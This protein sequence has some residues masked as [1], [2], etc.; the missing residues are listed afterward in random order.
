[1][2]TSK[3]KKICLLAFFL[4]ICFGRADAQEYAVKSNLLYDVTA[5]LNAGVE[6]RFAPQWT[7][8]L[9]GNL[10]AWTFRDNVKWKH[11]ML[12][13]EAR[14]WFCDAWAGHFVGIHAQGGQ[15][16][17]GGIDSSLKILGTDFSVLKDR[18]YQGWMAGLGLAYGYAW[19]LGTHWNLEAEAGLGWTRCW[20]DTFRC[21]G[22]GK[23][24]ATGNVHD[25]FG[26]TKL[27]VSIVYLF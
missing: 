1:V 27:S 13:P 12:Q 24:V 9:S 23:K 15:F 5:T 14:Y 25:W 18:R 17:V 16:N 11:W 20:Y 7:V 21:A 26:P 10:N 4:P 6:H 2:I 3:F 8:D 22:C 19:I